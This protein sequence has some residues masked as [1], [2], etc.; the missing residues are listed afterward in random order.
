MNKLVNLTHYNS[1][2][3][4]YNFA[5]KQNIR[6]KQ[7][8]IGFKL[9]YNHRKIT[10]LRIGFKVQIGKVN[11][12]WLD[13]ESSIIEIRASKQAPCSDA[14]LVDNICNKTCDSEISNQ[15][16]QFFEWAHLTKNNRD[17]QN[18]NLILLNAKETMRNVKM[19]TRFS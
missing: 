15:S 4:S 7:K 11:T 9:K 14:P 1:Q 12:I 16:G 2:G 13:D 5:G 6:K 10:W 3:F 17:K 18:R 19:T 8:L